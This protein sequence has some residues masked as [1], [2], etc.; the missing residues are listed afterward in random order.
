[1]KII[2]V[3][4]R[5]TNATPTDENVRI[6]C[7]P[8]LFDQ[9]DEIHVSVA[10]SYDIPIAEI[11]AK[12]WEVIA[13]VKIG[14]PAFNEPSGE[15]VPGMYLKKG[16]TIT[17]RGCPNKCWFCSVW[18]REPKLVE[19]EIKDGW[20]VLDDNLLACSDDHINAVFDMLERQSH[21]PR[22]TG[23][24]EAKRL[25]A[26]H[27]GRLLKLNPESMYFAYD[28]PDD[29]EPLIEAGKLLV[30]AGYKKSSKFACC[31]VLIGHQKDTMS[32]AEKRLLQTWDAG[33][34]PMAMLWR[35]DK[36]IAS[37]EWRKFARSWANHY[38]VG[39]KLKHLGGE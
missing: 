11:L 24:L 37:K 17:S 8:G 30:E 4:P 38:I 3:F 15:F 36:G 26:W 32:A 6:N 7:Y 18:K 10:F 2:R 23:G 20:N 22:F 34:F 25:K 13:P 21:R 27:V 5:K 29:L 33:F 35:N 31:Y 12:A 28:A 19:L 39:S 14:G 1:M 16:Y 9:A